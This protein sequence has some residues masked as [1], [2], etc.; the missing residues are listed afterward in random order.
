MRA[1]VLGAAGS[2]NEYL[3]AL[4]DILRKYPRDTAAMFNRAMLY[5]RDQV[6]KSFIKASKTDLLAC[7]LGSYFSPGLFR[8]SMTPSKSYELFSPWIPTMLLQSTRLSTPVCAIDA[9]FAQRALL[10]SFS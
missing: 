6:R 1:A 2:P 7:C 10:Y 4:D 8:K 3:A 9:S 5:L